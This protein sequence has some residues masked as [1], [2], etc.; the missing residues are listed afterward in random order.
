MKRRTIIAV[1]LVLLLALAVV[2]PA[3]ATEEVVATGTVYSAT[4]TLN[5]RSGPGTQY[6][7]VGILYNGDRVEIYEIKPT[8]G[9][10][11]GRIDIG[12]ISLEYVELDPDPTEAPDDGYDFVLGTGM[13]DADKDV[14]VYEGPG[15][16]YAITYTLF[17]ESVLEFYDFETADGIEW[18]E[19]E[20]GWVNMDHVTLDGE[21]IDPATI[22][23][24]GMRDGVAWV[25]YTDG[26]LSITG[27]STSNR[28]D[29]SW[30]AGWK[31]YADRIKAVRF[32]PGSIG[33]VTNGSLHDLP[34]LEKVYVGSCPF[35]VYGVF[36]GCTNFT[37]Y[38][39]INQ[40]GSRY[41][42]QD[43]L[44]LDAERPTTLLNCPVGVKGTL[45]LPDGI[46]ELARWAFVGCDQ[47]EEV[48]LPEGL[49]AVDEW[50]F[51]DCAGL[52]TITFPASTRFLSEDIF[53]GCTSLET[54]YFEGDAP[55]C[56]SAGY[57]PF[58]DNAAGR[59]PAD[60]RITATAYYPADNPTWTRDAMNALGGNIT[61]VPVGEGELPP[62]R[63]GVIAVGKV[64]SS[65]GSL[66]IRCGPGTA[67]EKAGVLNDGDR[68]EIYEYKTVS[69]TR[70]GRIDMGWISMDYVVLDFNQP[71]PVAIVD[72]GDMNG[73]LLWW[74]FCE[75]GKL[76]LS[77]RS[78]MGG[79]SIQPESYPWYKY[80]E[81]ITDV[82]TIGNTPY[83]SGGAFGGYTNLTRVSLCGTMESIDASAFSGCTG[84]ETITIPASVTEI[85]ESAFADCT[86][87]KEVV[88]SPGSELATIGKSAFSHSGLEA[89]A[90]PETLRTIGE[91]AFNGCAA[92]TTLTL[93]DGI[94]TIDH[95]AFADCTA[96]SG[97]LYL[98]ESI[99]NLYP[100]SFDDCP[101]FTGVTINTNTAQALD[102]AGSQVLRSVTLGG[103]V[104]SP[105]T[106][107]FENCTALTEV[108]IHSP[109]EEIDAYA[110]AG[111][112]ALKQIELPDTLETITNSAFRGS[113][114]TSITFPGPVRKLDWRS[115]AE[116]ADLTEII[117][118]SSVP[119]IDSAAFS[120]VTAT[121]YYPGDNAT[122][123]ADVMLDYGG[124]LT[125]EPLGTTSTATYGD[126]NGDG[127]INGLDTI[128][129]RQH[130]AGWGVTI[131][132]SA[133]DV[134][135]DGRVNALDMILLRQYV[136]GWDVSLGG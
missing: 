84:L 9:Y 38:E 60:T 54:I 128:L 21:P 87:L 65:V 88:L 5:V 37:A 10:G 50:A 85:K 124:D 100:T 34:N 90:L 63:E 98:S 57:S 123:T 101:G 119:S 76:F 55:D 16:T 13:T 122:W 136:A 79:T 15:L 121:A 126:V 117:F 82:I 28:L 52:K 41:L 110:F 135:G 113:G 31:P 46:T 93:Q 127:K 42:A 27:D 49:D 74:K 67:Y 48:I 71:D 7:K 103:N 134:N 131:D 29:G 14:D 97:D 94:T 96:L 91:R 75:D 39:V 6:E 58:G 72:S 81:R 114:L 129:L 32:D 47:L 78:G 44:L 26:T 22:T 106:F 95:Y 109:L 59:D 68:V 118:N 62:F 130:L 92:L 116:C 3:A 24:K 133:S 23:A 2:I 64:S 19:C 1:L 25:L 105:G 108:V 36:Q 83:I 53:L 30:P 112:T 56:S 69:G 115:F 43:G 111:C 102:F 86:S 77:G 70:W 132:P 99:E 125:W 18:G 11:W 73:H 51:Q 120:G 8:V 104:V 17:P 89:I 33:Y 20:Y 107:A 66:N 80:R 40:P 4:G 12:W 35:S 61:W 45:E